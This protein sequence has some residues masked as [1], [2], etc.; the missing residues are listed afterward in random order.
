MPTREARMME[1]VKGEW[2]ILAV[3]AFWDYPKEMPIEKYKN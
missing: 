2:K 1:K 3:L